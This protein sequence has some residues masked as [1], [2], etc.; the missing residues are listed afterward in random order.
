VDG[1]FLLFVVNLSVW[2]NTLYYIQRENTTS[3]CAFFIYTKGLYPRM[4]TN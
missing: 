3:K 1:S 2:Q 4:D